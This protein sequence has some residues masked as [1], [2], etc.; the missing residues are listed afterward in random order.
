MK[1]K[2]LPLIAL[3]WT[4][5]TQNVMAQKADISPVPQ[6]ITWGEKAFDK[7]FA[8]TLTGEAD[9][10]SISSFSTLASASGYG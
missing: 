5:A 2:F 7:G 4:C 10:D 6:E 3:A 8:Y 9:A 1:L